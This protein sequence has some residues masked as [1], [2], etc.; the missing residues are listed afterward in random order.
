MG[1]AERYLPHY[2]VHDYE[3]WKGDWELIEGVPFALASPSYEHQLV[4][5]K[6]FRYISEALDECPECSVV[7]ETDWYV[8]ED[9]VVRPDIMVLCGEVKGKVYIAPELVVEI[10]SKSTERMDERIKFELYEREGVPYYLLIY[11]ETKRIK[12][13]RL[14]GGRY[15]AGRDLRITLAGKCNLLLSES[16]IP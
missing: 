16:L 4:A 14:L 9:T 2:T 11:P 3:S 7:Y 5:G 10:V 1:L 13:Y 6:V 8:S 12:L 15:V